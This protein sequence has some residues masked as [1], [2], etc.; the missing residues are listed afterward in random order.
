MLIEPAAD[1]ERLALDR[2]VA[3][4]VRKRIAAGPRP[5]PDAEAIALRD[6]LTGLSPAE[7]AAVQA[8]RGRIDAAT[9]APLVVWG[10]ASRSLAA[11][12][13]GLDARTAAEA[14][15]ALAAVRDGAR[16]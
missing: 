11:D 6:V 16:A 3:E 2:A 10:S 9:G 1:A 8:V 4:A 14:E 5:S 12:R 13:F 7:S 15:Q